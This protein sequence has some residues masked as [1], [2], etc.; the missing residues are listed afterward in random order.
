MELRPYQIQMTNET[1]QHFKNGIRCVLN[2]GPTGMG[3]TML[4]ASMLKTAASKNIRSIFICHRRE[5][6]KQTHVAFNALI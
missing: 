3:K 1:R 5:L 2:Q 6:I 4:V